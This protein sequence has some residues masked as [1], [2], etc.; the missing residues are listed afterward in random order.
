LE[1]IEIKD[2]Y[3]LQCPYPIY[4][5]VNGKFI[6]AAIGF[7]YEKGS[8]VRIFSPFFESQNE[9]VWRL[10]QSHLSQAIFNDFHMRIHLGVYHFTTNQYNVPMYNY[11]NGL[12]K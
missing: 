12:S 5:K 8:K 4:V 7:R 2:T 1:N 11:L 10:A 3:Y 9:N 6:C